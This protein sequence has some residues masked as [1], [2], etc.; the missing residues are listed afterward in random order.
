VLYIADFIRPLGFR[1]PHNIERLI[2]GAR[3]GAMKNIASIPPIDSLLADYQ[4]H[5]L[6]NAG[7]DLKPS[8][9]T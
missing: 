8:I 4:T 1:C 2:Q 6:N 7:M 3:I 5:L 9:F